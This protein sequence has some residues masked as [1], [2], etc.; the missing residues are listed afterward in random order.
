MAGIQDALGFRTVTSPNINP[1]TI[2]VNPTMK[3]KINNSADV[4]NLINATN[5]PM[6]I[7]GYGENY[8]GTNK[9]INKALIAKGYKPSSGMNIQTQKPIVPSLSQIDPSVPGVKMASEFDAGI[10]QLPIGIDFE[11]VA[12]GLPDYMNEIRNLSNLKTVDKGEGSESIIVPGVGDKSAG[13]GGIGFGGDTGAGADMNEKIAAQE[14]RNKAIIADESRMQQGQLGQETEEE[15]KSKYQE[16]Q[17]SLQALFTTAMEEQK[18]LFGDLSDDTG[19]KSIEDYKAQ[20]QKATGIDVSGEPDN[21]MALMSL[22]L[23]LMQN[24]AGKGFNLSNILTSVGEA[25]EAS[26]PAFQKAKDDARAGQVAAGK[27]ALQQTQADEKTKLALSKEK[28]LALSALSK[29]FRT[30]AENRFLNKESHLNTMEQKE[31][32]ETIKFRAAMI[33]AGKDSTEL[34]GKNLSIKPID[35]QTQLSYNKSLKKNATGAS[36]SVF[37]T[38]PEDIRKFKDAAFNISRARARLGGLKEIVGKFVPSEGSGTIPIVKRIGDQFK[39]YAVAFGVDPKALFKNSKVVG[40]DENG[41]IKKVNANVSDTDLAAAIRDSLI[42]EYKKFL[43]QETG[44]GI[45]NQDVN[46]LKE[47]IGEIDFFGNPAAAIS[48]IEEI[49]GI[50]LKTQD[51]IGNVFTAFRDK[52]NYMTTGQYE[53]AMGVLGADKGGSQV[54]KFGK[55]GKSFDVRMGSDGRMIYSLQKK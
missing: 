31:L 41:N 53:K 14:E 44:N 47:A 3:T 25:G 45:S 23:S 43:T 19:E 52:D 37:T 39:N 18:Q 24:K 50:F 9:D 1:L 38:A 5:N 15:P 32:T 13:L 22:G 12:G 55:S 34:S 35:G 8:Y 29:E 33:K 2:D 26:M 27:Y 48:R 42:L 4:L 21:K 20:F 6:A 17:D 10:A 30:T 40:I 51:Q 49:D 36:V 7:A 28:R 16:N 46:R 11:T 54:Y